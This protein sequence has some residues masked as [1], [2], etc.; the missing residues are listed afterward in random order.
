[1]AKFKRLFSVIIVIALLLSSSVLF[2]T[3]LA[4]ADDGEGGVESK[5]EPIEVTRG[6]TCEMASKAEPEEITPSIANE[7]E[8]KLEKI[9]SSASRGQDNIVSGEGT[10]VSTSPIYAGSLLD[11]LPKTVQASTNYPLP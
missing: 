9:S 10:I 4:T 6:E 2:I 11:N 1:M 8:V 3:Q 5:A 7:V